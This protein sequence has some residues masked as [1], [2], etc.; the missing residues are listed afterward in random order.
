MKY[1]GLCVTRGGAEP[2]NK[3]IKAINNMTPLTS[4]KRVRMFI[5]LV[6]DYRN[7]WER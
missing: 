2:L 1:L 4:Q 7:I 3:K 5:G 6:K